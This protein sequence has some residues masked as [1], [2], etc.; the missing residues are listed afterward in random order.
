MNSIV[1][2]L[3]NPLIAGLVGKPD[4]TEFLEFRIGDALVQPGAVITALVYFLLVARDLLL[5][6]PAPQQA[7]RAPQGARR[8]ARA[9]RRG[10]PR[11]HGDP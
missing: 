10:R 7:R 4:F 6:R 11:A 9:R 3:L 5:R 2:S 1:N 8:R